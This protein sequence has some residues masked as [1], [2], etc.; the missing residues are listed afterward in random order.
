VFR[1]T[2]IMERV[3]DRLADVY[4]WKKP[5]SIEARTCGEPGATWDLTQH[6]VILCYELAEE[7]VQLYKLHGEDP[8]TSLS[9]PAGSRLGMP[10]GFR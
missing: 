6:K 2:G 7:F 10:L 3:A 8:L 9:P 1:S 5:F 4:A